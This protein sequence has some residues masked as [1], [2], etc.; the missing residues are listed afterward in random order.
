MMAVLLPAW[1][2][3]V[4]AAEPVEGPWMVANK[5]ARIDI[6]DCNGAMW[7]FVAWEKMP[8]GLDSQ[9][10]DPAKRS[11]STLGMPIL[12]GMK[13]DDKGVWQGQ[14]YNSD[15][16]KFYSGSLRL[17]TPNVLSVEGCVLG[18]LCGGEDWARYEPDANTAPA[19]IA[20]I[21]AC[22]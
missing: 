5:S 7:G 22:P 17:R 19:A 3:A 18:I 6:I 1:A 2:A 4:S 15:N 10:P 20:S 14:I 13:A 8:G 12:L 16:G 11:R 9:N 21:G